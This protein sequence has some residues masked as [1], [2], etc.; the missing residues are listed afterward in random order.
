M[1]NSVIIRLSGEITIKSR[2]VRNLWEKKIYNRVRSLIRDNGEI[3]R[4]G[5]R[6]YVLTKSVEE[7]I[8]R[9]RKISGISSIS[10]A[11]MCEPKLESIREAIDIF[12]RHSMSDKVFTF[13]IFIDKNL[14]K[15]IPSEELKRDLGEYVRRRYGL[16]VRLSNPDI[17]I[18]LDIRRDKVFI[19]RDRI[20]GLG[21]LPLGIQKALVS[22]MSGGPDSTLATIMAM[23]RG[24]RIIGIYFDFGAEELREIARRRV[25]NI[26]RVLANDYGGLLK[27]YIVPF[28]RISVASVIGIDEK[29]SYVIVKRY[30]MRIAEIIAKHEDAGGIV[31]GEI[32]GEHASQIIHNLGIISEAVRDVPL[33]RP[34]I[35]MNKEEIFKKLKEIDEELYQ[36]A[37]KSIEPCK[38]LASIKPTTKAKLEKVLE[39]EKE[40]G[41][42]EQYLRKLAL[43]ESV[44]ITKFPQ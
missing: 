25:L 13:G 5:A 15:E 33:I 18:H 22:L 29:Y 8:K 36:L 24:S 2:P 38:D 3:V 9:L 23:R 34:V 31:T 28:T 11:I 35:G 21:G 41:I 10:P 6:F 4:E 43:E 14:S 27:L 44:I 7:I 30:M 39:I 12:V 16:H 1:Y 32:I 20:N 26:A 19:Y 37:N 40:I 17:P 42:T